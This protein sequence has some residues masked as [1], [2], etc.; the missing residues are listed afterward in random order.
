M[1]AL[2]D[3]PLRYELA[4]ELHARPFPSVKVP[5]FAVYLAIKQP[6]NAATRDRE[7]DRAHLLNLL[8]RFGAPHPKPGAT[9]FFGEIGKHH[10]KWEQHTEFVTYTVFGDQASDRAF[11]PAL[12]D[13][14]PTDWLAAA[15]GARVTSALIRL[16]RL[17]DEDQISEKLAE[18]MVPESLAVSYV[19]DQVAVMAGDFRIDAAGHMRF[20]I[21]AGKGTEDSRI[22]RI[23]QRVCE[24]E[25]Y[26]AMSMLGLARAQDLSRQMGPLHSELSGLVEDMSKPDSRAEQ[27]LQGLLRISA[28]L[29]DLLSK[30]TFRFGATGAYGAL[31]DQRIEVLRETRFRGRQTFAEFMMRR[32]DPAM[33]TVKSTENRLRDMA[34]AAIRAGELLRTQV[35]VERSA[36]NQR[37]MESMDKRADLQL[38]LQKT[39][40]GLSVVAISYYAVNLVSYAA[41]PIFEHL[42]LGK[43]MATA[44]L[45][46]PVV[47]AV[48]YLVHRIRQSV[49]H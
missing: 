14:F 6:K 39:V 40:E 1:S 25:T 48:W 2:Q 37:L 21:F 44:V 17:D 8:D 7:A 5:G 38:R 13:V 9:H 15:P 43:G 16:E 23:V 47:L 30:S 22:G 42:H 49:D 32:F 33:R 20:A 4:N 18:W 36:Q 46:P 11:D 29:E 24:V 26:K 35:D 31:V 10:L 45:T 41:Y 12:F 19:L 34:A 27:T 3:H 28:K